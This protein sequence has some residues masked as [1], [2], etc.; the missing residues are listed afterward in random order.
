MRKSYAA[1]LILAVAFVA[2]AE[3]AFAQATNPYNVSWSSLSPN[4]DWSATVL[5]SL[6]P[7][8]GFTQGVSTG[9]ESTVI[10]QL[11]G[12]FTGFVAAIACAFVSYNIIMNIHRAA[13]SSQVLGSGQT[14]MAA[15]RIG[16]AAIMMFPLGGGFC[17]GQEMV[18]Q[19]AMWGV[20]MAK[21][22]YTNAIQAVGPDA[23][24]IATPQIPGTSNIVANLIQDQLCMDLV[25]L[26][27]NGS[28][29]GT[30]LIPAPQ[31]LSANDGQGSGYVTW[32]YSL[33]TGDGSG[34]PACGSVTVREAAQNA[35]TIE[36]VN[37]DMAATQQ[38]ILTNVINGDLQSQVQNVAQSLW[39]TKTAASLAALQGIYSAAVA[40]YT[41]QLTTAATS[42]TQQI[43]TAI[44]TNAAAA[45]NGNLDLLASEQQQSTLGWTSAGA[46]YLEI[47]RLNAET[48]SVLNAT[49]DV[50]S[51]TYEGLGPSLSGDLAP[52]QTSAQ[53][54]V[55]ALMTTAT[56]ADG[57]NPPSGVPTTLA[58]ATDAAKGQS[59]L[60]QLFNAIGLN[61]YVLNKITAFLLPP[62][63][64][65]TDPFGGLMGLGQTLMNVSLAGFAGA[66]ILASGTGTAATTVWNVLTGDW[67]AA[68]ATVALHPL[69]SFLSIPIFMLLTAILVPGMMISYALPMV[70]YVMWMAGVCGWIILVCEAMIAVPLWMLAHMTI[71]GDGLHGRAIEGWGLLF[72]VMFRPTLMILGLFLSYFV[73]DCMSWLER[74]SFGIAVG[75][76][77]ANG[78]FVT[79]LIGIVVLLNIFVMLQVTTAI[80]SFRMIALLP[81]HLPRLLGFTAANRVDIEAF[82][83]Q[84]AWGAGQAVAGGTKQALSAG[85]T[86]VNAVASENKKNLPGPPSGL[87]SGPEGGG[88]EGM[89][90]TL[91]ATTDQSGQ[92]TDD[93][94]A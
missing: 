35:S 21:S 2:M 40:D 63:Q 3:P 94:D 65:W 44:Q 88:R 18:M 67:A 79:N 37:V 70:P 69:V 77:L 53:S 55:Q 51:P 54:Y 87:I 43:N 59:V 78:W 61:D 11:V 83:Q 6:F 74:E 89:D 32:N 17:A 15:V 73:F 47:A 33:A 49:P 80:M 23:I 10:G 50:T 46:Y 52:V 42:I 29:N 4:G 57:T 84:A 19:G 36:G 85:L 13:E 8:P 93:V 25:N 76:I 24:V 86:G 27:G 68:A 20:G 64:V 1:T 60:A 58:S 45:R 91:R 92:G 39:D 30:P 48:L 14:W 75:F 56:T 28:G 72:N 7:I 16:F 81:H 41:E 9:N 90:S 34:D 71:G 66:G 82:Q 22:L 62:T 38:A 26:A 12:Q 31:P 5:Q